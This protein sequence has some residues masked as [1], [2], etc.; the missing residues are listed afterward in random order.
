MVTIIDFRKEKSES[1]EEYVRLIL[2][3]NDLKV[4]KTNSGKNYVSAPKASVVSSISMA[5]AKS[6]VGNRLPGT[7]QPVKSEP[8]TYTDKETGEQKI[9]NHSYRYFPELEEEVEEEVAV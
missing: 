2:Q 5:M 8:W 6:Q 1:G 4:I 3:S 9:Y 7:I